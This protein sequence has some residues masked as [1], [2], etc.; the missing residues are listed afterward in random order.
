MC[1]VIV[2]VGGGYCWFILF[3]WVKGCCGVVFVVFVELLP[4]QPNAPII[5]LCAH[6]GWEKKAAQTS[7]N[8]SH[9]HTHAHNLFWLTRTHIHAH[10]PPIHAQA[11]DA[12]VL[13]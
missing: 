11:I 13:F 5:H 7:K 9:T 2:V 8:P 4:R 10:V 1:V 3:Q 6:L 12:P